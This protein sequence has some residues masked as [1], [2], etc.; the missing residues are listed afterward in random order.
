MPWRCVERAETCNLDQLYTGGTPKQKGQG[1]RN[2]KPRVQNRIL[3]SYDEHPCHF[4]MEVPPGIKY[5]QVILGR[6]LLT[7]LMHNLELFI[8]WNAGRSKLAVVNALQLVNI[9]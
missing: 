1:V 5:E 6:F 8:E 9:K 7:W 4:H 3:V 2:F